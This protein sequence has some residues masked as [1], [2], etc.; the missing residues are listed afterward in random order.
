MRVKRSSTVVLVLE[1]DQVIFHNFLSQTTFAANAAALELASRV[2]RWTEPDEIKKS[3]LSY[4]AKSVDSAIQQLIELDILIVEGSAAALR[5]A[6][7]EQA[8]LWGSMAG[9]YHFGSQGGVFVSDEDT[10]AML[11]QV[12]MVSP[13]PILHQPNPEG[14]L[15]IFAPQRRAYDEPFLTM[16]RRRTNRIM[17]DESIGLDA[18]ADCLLVS[19][20]I[21][22]M[23]DIPGV[24]DLPL[25][26]TPSGGARNPYEAYVLARKVDGLPRGVYHY[27][28][29]DQSFAPLGDAGPPPFPGLL[30]QQ[31]WTANAAAVILLVANFDRPMWK[32]HDPA[33]YRVTAI[34][35]GHIA[36]NIL[37]AATRLGLAGNPTAL[38]SV[39]DLEAML[40]LDAIT[41]SATYAVALGVPAPL[42]E[43]DVVSIVDPS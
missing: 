11:R 39:A 7:Y 18:V 8:W 19:M 21:T 13:S 40:G 16:A 3:M 28:A 9:A 42:G 10:Q 14:P 33:A 4:T 15:K 22:A 41:Q 5:D 31:A 32:Y 17:L 6:R 26:M 30:G 34:E 35:A 1:N 24:G 36:Q 38:L 29:I 25:K 2:Y 20:A 27:A 12:A 23:L 43:D 37:L